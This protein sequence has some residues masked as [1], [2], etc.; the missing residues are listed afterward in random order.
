MRIASLALSFDTFDSH[1][2]WQAE[3]HCS[4]L[5]AAPRLLKIDRAALTPV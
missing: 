5:Y 3:L 2:Q 1:I 4:V